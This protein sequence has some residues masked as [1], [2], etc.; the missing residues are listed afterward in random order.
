MFSGQIAALLFGSGV[1]I[2]S[3]SFYMAG[4]GI[5]VGDFWTGS[6]WRQFLVINFGNM[7]FW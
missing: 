2:P 7:E 3:M 6:F 5:K 4:E 1:R